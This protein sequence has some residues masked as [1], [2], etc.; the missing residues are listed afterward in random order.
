VRVRQCKKIS[1]ERASRQKREQWRKRAMV[2]SVFLGLGAVSLFSGWGIYSGEFS[3]WT[4]RHMQSLWETTADA[5]FSLKHV[6]L[7]GH[8]KVARE[9]VMATLKLRPYE[10]ILALPLEVLQERLEALPQ[11]RHAHITRNLP[12][13]LHIHLEERNP[14]AIWQLS[15]K[16]HLVD[17]DGAALRPIHSRDVALYPGLPL[18]VGVGANEQ[19][20]ALFE[21][22]AIKPELLKEV[23]AAIWVGD[24][25]W[26][27]RFR[28]GMEVKLPEDNPKQAWEKFTGLV[29]E[30]ALLKRDIRLIDMRLPDRMFMQQLAQPVAEE[31]QKT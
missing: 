28:K 22:L 4:D 1:A 6:Y 10:P 29:E 12:E 20:P 13:S 8:E 16:L 2:A 3:R 5:G 7:S 18:V 30:Y 27:I 25:R 19:L 17:E 24:R 21:V 15:G 11:V 14:A 23:E 9:Q 26:D 31:A